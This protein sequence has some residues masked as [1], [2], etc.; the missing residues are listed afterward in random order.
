VGVARYNVH[1]RTSAA[2]PERRQPDRA[3]GAGTSYAD[4]GLAIGSYFYKVTAEDAAGNISAPST[5]VSATVADGT[6]R[7]RRPASRRP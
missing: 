3:A 5:Q 6:R 4:T 1:R 2:S 7:P